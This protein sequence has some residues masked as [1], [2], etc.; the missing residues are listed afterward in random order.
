M[1]LREVRAGIGT[2]SV[3][4]R[5][6]YVAATFAYLIFLVLIPP[7]QTNDEDA[8]WMRLWTTASGGLTCNQ[9]IPPSASI[10][11]GAAHY[12]PVRAEGKHYQ[13]AFIDEELAVV[14]AAGEARA[15]GA[16]CLYMPISYLLPAVAARLVASPYDAG[17]PSHMFHAF[18]AA[19]GC[20]L[21]LLV[22][23]TLLFLALVPQYRNLTLLLYSLPMLMQQGISVNQ[24]STITLLFFVL[25]IFWWRQSTLAGAVAMAGLIALLSLAKP[26]YLVFYLVWLCYLIRL[27]Q[28]Q[29]RSLRWLFA[30]LPMAFVP[31]VIWLLWT[32]LV[33]SGS[34][35]YLPSWVDMPGQIQ[36]L[37]THPMMLP[38]VI[39]IQ[40][41][42]LFGREHL[43]GGWISVLG[44][45][46]WADFEIGNRAYY[47]LLLAAVLAVA[48]DL[49]APVAAVA[50]EVRPRWQRIVPF[51]TFFLII[52]AI[53][54]AMYIQFS[55]VGS[56]YALGT[57]GRYL[58]IPYFGM[59]AFGIETARSRWSFSRWQSVAK[60]M[61]WICM[62]LCA[63]AAHDAIGAIWT[64][65]YG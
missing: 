37:K 51:W 25:M 29:A 56:P 47:C 12:Y 52:P 22:F 16:T 61:P 18:Y 39:L 6:W 60:V 38:K 55:G 10:F 36:Y 26:V 43:R 48:A 14:G 63:V 20:N 35:Q 1:G 53:A 45:L 59:L 62:A 34:Q 57:S 13:F 3:A 65:F 40:L 17:K 2:L 11:I 41:A 42:D 33:V 27:R 32:K 46:G 44:V 64:R 30:M 49:G 54:V 8:H 4:H 15:G 50:S 19:R 7:F 9:P 58:H 21:L 5:W 28:T 24:E 23:G 31:V